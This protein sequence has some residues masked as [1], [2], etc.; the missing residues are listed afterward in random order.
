MLLKV[1]L[2]ICKNLSPGMMW[3]I[4]SVKSK[5]EAQVTLEDR[6]TTQARFTFTELTFPAI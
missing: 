4:T 2:T 1:L 3:E 6:G 5:S